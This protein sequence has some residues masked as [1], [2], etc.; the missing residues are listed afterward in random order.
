MA[1]RYYAFD[2]D[3]SFG[4]I[5]EPETSAF[6]GPGIELDGETVALAD[7]S[8]VV[9][10]LVIESL[11]GRGLFKTEIAK[12]LGI[13]RQALYKKMKRSEEDSDDM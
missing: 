10:Q 11:E 3:N 7:L 13:S 4:D 2:G 9:E 8:K 1:L 6:D 5:L 12:K